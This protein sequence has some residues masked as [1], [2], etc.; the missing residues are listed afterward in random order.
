MPDF[1]FL[2]LAAA[3]AAPFFAGATR[4]ADYCEI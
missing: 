4:S 3:A 2:L 1:V